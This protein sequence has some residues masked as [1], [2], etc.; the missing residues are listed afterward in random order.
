MAKKLRK[1]LG[2]VNAPEVVA[3]MRLIDTQSKATICNWCMDYAEAYILPI[4][5]KRCPG[6]DRPRSALNAARDYLE[7]KVKFPI[8][9]DIILNQ[10]HPA[11]RELDSDPAA[12]AAAR[13]CG[14]GSAVV[15]TLSHSLGLYFYGAAA[16]AYDRIGTSGAAEEYDKIAAEVCADLTTALQAVAIADEPN[17]AKIKWHC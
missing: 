7:G 8:V 11:A 16:V 17:P 15:H 13:A 14:Q 3:L 5:E 2:D 12:Q 10:C 1:M 4:F 9:K 6:D